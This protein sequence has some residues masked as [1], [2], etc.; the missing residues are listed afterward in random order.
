MPA[1]LF[2]ELHRE[3][4]FTLD[5]A[6]LPY[7]AKCEQYFTPGFDGLK[8]S[9]EGVCWMNPPYGPALRKWVKK[10]HESVVAGA[11]VVCLLPGRT[12]THWWHARAPS[13]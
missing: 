12:D 13:L 8:Q 4:R 2:A 1:E 9:W 11:T 10:A 3:F 7:N 5:V 6:A